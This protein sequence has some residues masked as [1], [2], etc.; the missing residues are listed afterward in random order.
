MDSMV[1]NIF[2]HVLNSV[3]TTGIFTED[4]Q[5]RILLEIV[6]I[7]IILYLA[8]QKQQQQDKC[9]STRVNQHSYT[10]PL[11]SFDSSKPFLLFHFQPPYQFISLMFISSLNAVMHL[12]CAVLKL[13]QDAIHRLPLV[14]L[15]FS[16]QLQAKATQ[17]NNNNKWHVLWHDQTQEYSIRHTPATGR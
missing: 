4:I 2:T 17:L 13:G 3:M 8:L 9:N 12:H 16:T 6:I 14:Q 5:Q 15:I 7:L 10:D 1:L 11:T